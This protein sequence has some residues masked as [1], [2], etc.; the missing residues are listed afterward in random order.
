MRFP[1]RLLM[2]TTL[3]ALVGC[4][5][6]SDSTL[7]DSPVFV[8]ASPKVFDYHRHELARVASEFGRTP[9]EILSKEATKGRPAVFG[10]LQ[11]ICS[12]KYINQR[13]M[14]EIE[15]FTL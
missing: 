14:S 1:A 12:W 5:K 7:S 2:F 4:T 9:S 10:A 13:P 11:L 6:N 8:P 3:L 15:R